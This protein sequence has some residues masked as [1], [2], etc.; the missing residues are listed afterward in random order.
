MIELALSAYFESKNPSDFQLA[1]ARLREVSVGE[2]QCWS[3][4]GR[5]NAPQTEGTE[6]S[7]I[8]SFEVRPEG[9][10]SIPW[11]GTDA[12][13]RNE[14]IAGITLHQPIPHPTVIGAK[15]EWIPVLPPGL[16]PP[17][18]ADGVL[19]GP[20][21]DRLYQSICYSNYLLKLGVQPQESAIAHDLRELWRGWPKR[22]WRSWTSPEEPPEKVVV[23][24]IDAEM[25]DP[26]SDWG[27]KADE[28]AQLVFL[29]E[30]TILLQ[31]PQRLVRLD[32]STETNTGSWPTL[33][34]SL[35]RSLSPK[36]IQV[37]GYSGAD[38]PEQESLFV[39]HLDAGTW[40]P[41]QGVWFSESLERSFLW[42]TEGRQTLLVDVGDYPVAYAFTTDGLFVWVEDKEGSGGVFRTRD[43]SKVTEW[44]REDLREDLPVLTSK[45]K[46]SPM[47][48]I[49][50]YWHSLPEERSFGAA[51]ARSG[52]GWV[53]LLEDAVWRDEQPLFALKFR[54]HAAAFWGDRRIAVA[55][56]E[57]LHIIDFQDGTPVLAQRISL[58]PLAPPRAD[59][60]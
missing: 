11:F 22:D 47:G 31:F 57:T 19:A 23:P 15:V 24:P 32:L 50:Q 39:L 27:P 40:A 10:R 48:D 26:E 49:E 43:A 1:Q 34:T 58:K 14:R 21:I 3:A 6:T 16:R 20:E 53:Y 28:V 35:R 46:V 8:T 25:W 51:I 55:D 41:S 2:C 4:F 37:W 33:G 12:L 45:G 44:R 56:R 29:D 42:D 38:Y 60:K 30:T 54:A 52:A 59:G 9:L 36:E 13:T 18:W 7:W 5:G 17:T